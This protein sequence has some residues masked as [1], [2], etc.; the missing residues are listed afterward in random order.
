M[1]L[2]ALG[3]WYSNFFG[4]QSYTILP[5]DQVSYV[6]ELVAVFITLIYLCH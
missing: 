3:I 5:Y 6:D 1:I 2:A 4:S